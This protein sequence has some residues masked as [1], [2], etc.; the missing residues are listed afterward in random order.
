MMTQ[1]S[2]RVFAFS[3]MFLGL[4]S[5]SK[6]GLEEDVDFELIPKKPIV[7]STSFSYKKLTGEV[8]TNGDPTFEDVEVTGPWYQ[9]SYKI[10]NKSATKTLTIASIKSTYTGIGIDS[11]VVTGSSEFT[12]DDLDIT[13]PLGGTQGYLVEIPPDTL[14]TAP[15]RIFTGGLPS[16]GTVQNLR[17]RVRMEI[18]GWEGTATEPQKS[19]LKIINFST[20][21]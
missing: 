13:D 8:D 5:C 15:Y 14:Y 19:F 17:F 7:I 1:K 18:I 20:E 9:W 12:S 11:N 4:L 10:N 6:D 2:Y 16:L 21:D 3:I